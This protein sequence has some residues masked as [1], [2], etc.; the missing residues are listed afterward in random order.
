MARTN[1]F[2][3]SISEF[4]PKWRGGWEYLINKHYDKLPNIRIPNVKSL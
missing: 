4:L 3:N 1:G 2:M